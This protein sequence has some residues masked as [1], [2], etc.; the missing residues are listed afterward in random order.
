MLLRKFRTLMLRLAANRA[1]RAA[2]DTTARALASAPRPARVLVVCHGNIY[3]SPLV[4]TRLREKLGSA[5]A[6]TQGG[7]HSRGDRP[8][9]EAHVRMSAGQGVDL[10]AHRSRV[11]EPGDFTAADLI[12]LMDRRNWVNLKREGADERKFVWLGA[13][14]PG[15]VEIPDPYGLEAAQAER[16]VG[17]L[18][19]TTDALAQRL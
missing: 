7:F 2:R 9:P 6:I 11:L 10:S 15:E 4:A 16:I 18:I 17:R 14:A 1:L 13:L 19:A 8:S 12:V 3:R 5:R